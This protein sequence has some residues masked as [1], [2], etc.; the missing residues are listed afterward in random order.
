MKHVLLNGDVHRPVE[1][2]GLVGVTRPCVM[3]WIHAGVIK[4]HRIGSRFYI[5][6]SERTRLTEQY[7][8][9][10]KTK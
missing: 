5:P 8:V 4:S 7:A 3:K 2:A 9:K 10:T 1:F 6:D